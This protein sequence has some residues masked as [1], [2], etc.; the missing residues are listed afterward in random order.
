MKQKKEGGHLSQGSRLEKMQ[1][2]CEGT[3]RRRQGDIR[4]DDRPGWG[5]TV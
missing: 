3:P 1:A 4:R 2:K 5:C